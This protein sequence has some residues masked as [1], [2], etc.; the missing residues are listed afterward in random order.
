MVSPWSDTYTFEKKNR[1]YCLFWVSD[2]V[3]AQF[4]A[5]S[6]QYAKER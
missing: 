1:Q 3:W 4:R 5:L 6:T 2:I